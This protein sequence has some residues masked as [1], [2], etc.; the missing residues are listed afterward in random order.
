MAE[1]LDPLDELRAGLGEL[2]A[3]GLRRRR[4]IV[5]TPCQPDTRL[6]DR[7]G[8]IVAF[9]SNDYLG[10]AAEPAIAEAV[11]RGSLRWGS[12]SGASHL[13]SGHYAVH[14]GGVIHLV[15]EDCVAASDEGRHDADVG[16]VAGGKIEGVVHADKVGE[17][18]FEGFV[19]G[20]VA[21]D[22]VRGAGA[23]APATGAAGD[24][25]G[26]RRFGGEAEVV[27][28]AEGDE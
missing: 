10:L 13:V 25:F 12:G 3:S 19:T 7:A 9:C 11:R 8:P 17:A 2:D 16:H 27:V 21:A 1:H 4:R 23:D 26:Q 6:A 14:E 18:D 24:G 22:E 20:I 15:G 5:T 28:G